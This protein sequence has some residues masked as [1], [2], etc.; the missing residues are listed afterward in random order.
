MKEAKPFYKKLWFWVFI[1]AGLGFAVI[2]PIVINALYIKNEG[3]LTVW[4]GSDVLAYYGSLL[5]AAATIIAL[6]FTIIF[7]QKN[8][9]EERK[10]SVKPYLQTKYYLL[11]EYSDARFGDSPLFV[12]LNN[13]LIESY[14]D[15]PDDLLDIKILKERRNSYRDQLG[16]IFLDRS[17]KEANEKFFGENYV[18]EYKLKNYGS[19]TALDIE[20]G[21]NDMTMPWKY[22]IKTDEI[23]KI[24]LI[25]N[26]NISNLEINLKY[27]DIFHIG[28]YQQKESF[29]L[30]RYKE[31]PQIVQFKENLLT[32]PEEITEDEN[33]GQ[34]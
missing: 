14:S 10:L 11:K 4:D 12:Q 24:F 27:Y 16:Q 5:G 17:I 32:S 21:F 18:I 33:N 2:G 26:G 13:G 34:T 6:V 8:Q 1:I 28:K 23:K 9:K 25:V 20:M 19:N 31:E 30:R 22:C 3:Y 7:T 29:I 15:L